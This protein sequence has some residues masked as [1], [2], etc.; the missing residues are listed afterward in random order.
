MYTLK[1]QKRMTFL[2][3]LIVLVILLSMPFRYVHLL[4]HDMSKT[5]LIAKY[6]MVGLLAGYLVLFA[7][8][9][10]VLTPSMER[11]F[12]HKYMNDVFALVIVMA[13]MG[14]VVGF[15]NGYR[16]Y[17]IIGD[18]FRHISP[19][20][21]LFFFIWLLQG[22]IETGR[23][24]VIE[25]FLAIMAIIGI[26]EAIAT[27]T[28]RFYNPTLRI[29]TNLYFW[30]IIWV[31]YQKKLPFLVVL[32][33]MLVCFLASIASGKRSPVVLVAV[34]V[35][36]YSVYV[37]R[38]AFLR[39]PEHQRFMIKM[40]EQFLVVLLIFILAVT[41]LPF[42][43]GIISDYADNDLILSA[44]ATVSNVYNIVS[45]NTSDDS[46]EGRWT[47]WENII[48]HMKDKPETWLWGSGFG[49]EID[50][51]HTKMVLTDQGKMHNVH[52]AWGAYFLRSGILGL[53]V[54]F[55][56][57]GKLLWFFFTG[58][59]RYLNWQYYTITFVAIIIIGSFSSNVMLESFA[60]AFFGALLCSLIFCRVPERNF[61]LKP[62]QEIAIENQ[63]PG[64][65][66]GEDSYFEYD[67]KKPSNAK[68]YIDSM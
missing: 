40:T 43:N 59:T 64:I 65:D 60:D 32:P 38:L 58:G 17:Y 21:F 46:W 3:Y 8:N 29:S 30:G 57:F 14:V 5:Y 23:M 66:E 42:I 16:A 28:M 1:T 49:A 56:F 33:I 9:Y 34:I 68:Q 45:G 11:K 35:A 44:K 24:Y 13:V 50:P 26:I 18:A 20:L 48:S 47:E 6:T 55:Y 53:F 54:F 36:I 51:L 61:V 52:Q 27:L 4:L 10:Y 67:M 2:L 62:Y 39:S 15:A 12:N 31:L 37:F 22:L 19:W 41:S 63:A 7:I 25:R